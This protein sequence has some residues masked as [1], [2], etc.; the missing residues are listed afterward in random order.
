MAFEE[1]DD[2]SGMSELQGFLFSAFL[3]FLF[4]EDDIFTIDIKHDIL[5]IY[6][7]YK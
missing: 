7:L 1:I 3:G 5:N 2:Y 4:F 6:L